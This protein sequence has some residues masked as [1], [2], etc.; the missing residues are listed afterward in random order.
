MH[1]LSCGWLNPDIMLQAVIFLLTV[2]I[3]VFFFIHFLNAD[4]IIHYS[5]HQNASQQTR[6]HIHQTLILVNWFFKVNTIYLCSR[7]AHYLR[8][9]FPNINVVQ[10]IYDIPNC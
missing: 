2:I 4:Y 8:D 1:T 6:I 7:G 10:Q 3:K 5:S 9:D